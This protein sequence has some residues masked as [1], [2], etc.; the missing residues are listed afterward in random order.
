M[1]STTFEFSL[2]MP[3]RVK[4]RCISSAS[5]GRYFL[6][7]QRPNSAS[8]KRQEV[9]R[10]S[11]FARRFCLYLRYLTRW[12]R[13]PLFLAG[14]ASTYLYRYGWNNHVVL[15]SSQQLIE[16]NK[17]DIVMFRGNNIFAVA[18]GKV[19]NLCAHA[20]LDT[21]RFARLE[22]QHP[23]IMVVLDDNPDID[24]V[25]YFAWK[26]PFIRE[27]RQSLHKHLNRYHGFHF[28]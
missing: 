11:W 3:Q 20:Y 15:R 4:S 1:T 2:L 5:T 25:F 21:P 6:E 16:L 23:A 13:A 14:Q 17:G 12:T 18:G 27:T 10:T 28:N 7:R 19:N 8:S 22:Y 9:L 26:C 24:D